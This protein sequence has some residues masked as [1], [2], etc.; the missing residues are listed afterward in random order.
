MPSL[1]L[2]G[3]F[4]LQL[5]FLGRIRSWK[6][7]SSRKGKR[8][9]LYTNSSKRVLR[10]HSMEIDDVIHKHMFQWSNGSVLILSIWKYLCLEWWVLL[11]YVIVYGFWIFLKEKGKVKAETF[12]GCLHSQELSRSARLARRRCTLWSFSQLMVLAITS[13]ASNALTANPGFRYLLHFPSLCCC[14][15]LQ[16]R[17]YKM[18]RCV[19]KQILIKWMWIFFF[20]LLNSAEQIFING[21]CVVL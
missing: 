5:S 19:N 14:F 1:N 7:L 20:F 10:S 15:W 11:S 12:E 13:L 4:F 2:F 17:V 6:V 21:R 18:I 16:D 8:S 9:I 3:M